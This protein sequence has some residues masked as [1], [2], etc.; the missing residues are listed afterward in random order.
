M[1]YANQHMLIDEKR[2][3]FGTIERNMASKIRAALHQ[4][5]SDSNLFN[6]TLPSVSPCFDQ[7]GEL[8][9]FVLRFHGLSLSLGEC[10]QYA[11]C[12]PQ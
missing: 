7:R 3:P 6:N 1:M 9:F 2:T 10:S 11:H 8:T 5:E 12:T 4:M